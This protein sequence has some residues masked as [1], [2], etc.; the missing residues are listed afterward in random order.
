ME[1]A[2]S[3]QFNIPVRSQNISAEGVN[4]PIAHHLTTVYNGYGSVLFD[5][6]KL[7]METAAPQSADV[8]HAALVASDVLY[9]RDNYS[10]QYDART[11]RQLRAVNPNPWEVAWF[12]PEYIDVD[13]AVV[14]LVKPNGWQLSMWDPTFPGGERFL[15]TGDHHMAVDLKVRVSFQKSG[16]QLRVWVAALNLD[17]SAII[18]PYGDGMQR[19][20]VQSALYCEDSSIECTRWVSK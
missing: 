15:S 13:H 14:F 10:L 9:P 8:T 1:E 11:V 4:T 18:P 17:V 7:S 3:Q 5:G 19:G 16:N 20:V 2:M 6:Y 12:V